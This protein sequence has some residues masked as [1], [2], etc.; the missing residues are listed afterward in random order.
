MPLS[1][2]QLIGRT[3]AIG[4]GAVALGLG[5]SEADPAVARPPERRTRGRLFPPLQA[6]PGAL[7][8]LPEGFSYEVVAE[9]GVTDLEDGMGNVIGTTPGNADGTGVFTT[10]DGYRLVQNHERGPGASGPVPRVVGTVY[11]DA[12]GNAGGCTVLEVDRDG[13]RRSEWVGISG[14]ISNCAGGVTPWGSWLTCEETEAK[15]G[16]R[17]GGH[18]LARDHG[19]VF[20]VFPDAPETQ[21]SSPIKAWG[22]YAHEA[23]VVAP[24]A[25]R[26]TS[27]RTQARRT[28]SC[29][30]GPLPT[31]TA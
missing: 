6:A 8:A 28:G 7:L 20:E 13:S 19:Y 26:S 23:V 15:A 31:A 10:R 18:T 5:V 4:M 2:R 16:S 25:A 22:R 17:V 3:G 27:P 12:A 14:T 1:R 9:A 21:V 11:D 30:V 29:I 24:T